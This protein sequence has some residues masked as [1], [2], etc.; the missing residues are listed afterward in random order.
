M[1]PKIIFLFTGLLV[2]ALQARTQELPALVLDIGILG[3]PQIMRANPPPSLDLGMELSRGAFFK[4]LRK[5]ETLDAGLL[6]PGFNV[7]ALDVSGLFDTSGAAIFTLELKSGETIFRHELALE[8]AFDQ[9]TGTPAAEREPASKPRTL[10]KEYTISLY[11]D[12]Q[13]IAASRKRTLDRIS[14]NLKLPPMPRNYDPFN[15]DPQSD[16]MANSFSILDALGLAVH[17]ATR[18]LKKEEASSPVNPLRPLRQ[19]H[20]TFNRRT[21][22]G[23]ERPVSATVTLSLGDKQEPGSNR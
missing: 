8:I 3:G 4:L 23:L 2:L 18:L 17:M 19:V 5:G 12:Q 11:V 13:L 7:V 10:E 20:V 9:E 6:N 1:K 21:R 14:Y 16:P 15:P 22:Q